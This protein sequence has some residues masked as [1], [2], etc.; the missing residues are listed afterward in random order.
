MH[1]ELERQW[2][3]EYLAQFD[4]YMRSHPE[5]Y[6]ELARLD[7]EAAELAKRPPLPEPKPFMRRKPVPPV[8]AADPVPPADAIYPARL[9]GKAEMRR[10]VLPLRFAPAANQWSVLVPAGQLSGLA[11]ELGE[12]DL[13][14]DDELGACIVLG[15]AV[16]SVW[17]TSSMS[18]CEWYPRAYAV[19]QTKMFS[20]RHRQLRALKDPSSETEQLRRRLEALEAGR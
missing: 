16:A 14:Q 19:R 12:N 9:G 17:S 3:K 15:E 5:Q 20:A 7:K 18:P 11:E 2:A 6:P 8:P 13:F 10:L 4:A 1:A